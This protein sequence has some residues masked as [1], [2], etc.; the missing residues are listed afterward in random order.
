MTNFITPDIKNRNTK[1][2]NLS[3]TIC[4]IILY[5]FSGGVFCTIK[6]EDRSFSA[7]RPVIIKGEFNYPPYEFINELG[8]PDGFN[9]EIV[10]A[11]MKE[12]GLPYVLTLE[13]WG[14]VVDE[15]RR[16]E[17]DLLTGMMY[18]DERAKEFKFGAIHNHLFLNVIFRKNSQPIV[19]IEQLRGKEIVVLKKDIAQ[20]VLEEGGFSDE[21]ILVENLSE[22][23]LMLSKGKYDCAVTGLEM[24]RA[25]IRKYGIDNLALNSLTELP[26]NEY[27]FVGNNDLL[28]LK[29]NQAFFT[30]KENGTYDRIY[31]KWFISEE[32][33][34][35]PT[36]IYFLLIALA[37]VT[38][39]AVAF[40]R[41]LRQQVRKSNKELELTSRK[42]AL[43]LSADNI[44]VWGYDIRKDLLYNIYGEIFPEGG[45]KLS[46][47]VSL[48]HPDDKERFCEV[49]EKVI[50]GEIPDKP[51]V[52][53]FRN[54][55]T[56]EWAY[57]E[58]KFAS[59][60]SPNGVIEILIGTHKDVTSEVL[61]QKE[62]RESVRKTE[63]VI[64]ATN[65]VL[66]EFDCLTS[67]FK[68][69]NEPVN[70]YDE[71]RLLTLED[72]RDYFH[73]DDMDDSIDSI[74]SMLEG[75]E[76]HLSVDIR[77]KYPNEEDWHFCTVQG[78][79]LEFDA[80]TG[81]AVKY[82]GFRSDNTA[83]IL[84]QLDLEKEKEKAQQADRLK[85]TFLANMSHEIRTP[86]NAI[87]GFSNLLHE[88]EDE[89]ERS[90]FID[91]INTN[92][93]LLLRLINDIL[94]LSKIE[95]GAMQFSYSR[96]D[97]GVFFDRLAISLRQR[98]TN[99]DVEFFIEKPDED[100]SIYF[101]QNRLAQVCTN[102]TT[103]AIKYTSKGYVKL[104]YSYVNKG[105]RIYVEDTGIGIA[106]SKH[107]LVFQRFEKL[108]DF[109]QGTGLGLSICKAI[110]DAT[111]GEIGFT[112][113][114]GRGSTFWAWFP[115]SKK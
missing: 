7:E 40:I 33:I 106:E 59:I 77:I 114:E 111:Q 104:G 103:N 107:Y 48:V 75:E 71:T 15:L 58:K 105:I 67:T 63:L 76:E 12:L 16:G 32:Y 1:I 13:P 81:R 84:T 70:G 43:A 108:D 62:M 2:E 52:F 21:L 64:Q 102:F 61:N 113:E 18:T 30:I 79:P 91:I 24:A 47:G 11:V 26:I 86:L 45:M 100:H 25:V 72:Y 68:C 74:N 4:L 96:F 56:T 73:P 9:V 78:A 53:R 85:S 10:D 69:Y 23:L 55:D 99:P 65:T 6:A 3:L 17:V 83:M 49:F 94:D 35:I 115:C 36:Y 44:T 39:I 80:K 31:Q 66:W 97:M 5:I 51:V 88:V 46:D 93:D 37:L 109:A 38:L 54:H 95:A 50:S 14:Q 28:L 87:V 29:V 90:Q 22:A 41:M 8:E 110:A 60:C 98:I 101:D 20:E 57:I 92:S 112:S 42:L 27:C 19:D 89:E 34:Y 82:A